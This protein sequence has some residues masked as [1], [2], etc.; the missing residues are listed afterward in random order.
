MATKKPLPW[1]LDRGT[2][3]CDLCEQPHALQSQR[4]CT[5]CDRASCEHCVTVNP[6]TGEIRCHDCAGEAGE[7][8]G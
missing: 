7:E 5:A 4:R 1:W 3:S 6:G 2:E 8:Q